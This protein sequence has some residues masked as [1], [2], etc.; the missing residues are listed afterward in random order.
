MFATTS[1]GLYEDLDQQFLTQNE[2]AGLGRG[3]TTPQQQI[4][5]VASWAC[6][7]PGLGVRVAAAWK[8]WKVENGLWDVTLERQIL[9]GKLTE[10]E[11]LKMHE[12]N[13]HTLFRNGRPVCIASQGRQ[14][15]HWRAAHTG[16]YSISV[17][18]AGPFKPGR[19]WDPVACGYKYFLA[20]AGHPNLSGRHW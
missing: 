3:P 15:C 20:A 12:A 19:C 2:R 13:D 1:W 17:D 16:V 14:R 10:Q 4:K 9:L 7:A 8:A 18:I 6:W 5:K 11:A